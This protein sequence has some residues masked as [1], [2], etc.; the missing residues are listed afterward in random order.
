ME[1][2]FTVPFDRF[3]AWLVTHP[4]CILRAGTPE[5]VLFDDEDLH[6]SFMV[7]DEHT[8]LVQVL[9][10][11]RL[12]GELAID[13]EQVAY[14]EAVPSEQPDEFVFE[15]ISETESDRFAAWV[16]VLV[17]GWEDE[18]EPGAARVH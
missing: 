11:K 9:R 14:V 4:N 15:A 13:P 7:E 2:P 3:W 1:S 18:G 12:V 6:W 5:A 16:F 10:G 17:H 8:L